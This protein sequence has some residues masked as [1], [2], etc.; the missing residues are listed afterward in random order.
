MSELVERESQLEALSARLQAAAAGAG[1]VALVCG[2]AGIGKTSLVRA[3]AGQ[4]RGVTLWWGACDALQTPHPLAPLHDI[5][6]TAD[7][8][9]R[10]LIDSD[11]SRSALFEAVL[12]ELRDRP[13]LVVIEDAHW[14]DGATLDLIKFIGRRIERLPALLVVTYRDDEVGAQ[15]PL[16]R[17]IG[18]IPAQA[19]ARIDLAGLS[20]GAVEALA[21]QALR[22]PEGVHAATH[23]NPFFVTELLRRGEQ[24]VPR[25]V[26]DLV[27]ARLNR[28]GPAARAIVQLAS[29]FPARVERAVVDALLTPALA[30]LEACLDSGLLQG[31]GKW[32]F[33]RHEL[34]RGAVEGSLAAPLAQHLHVRALTALRAQSGTAVARLVHHAI[35]A[36][37][38]AAILEV[39]PRAAREAQA[40]G[41]H[42]EAAAHYGAALDAGSPSDDTC[43][44]WLEEFASECTIVDRLDDAIAARRE[45]M[46]VHKRRSS[47][48]GQVCNLSQLAL[49]Y[50][51]ALR[52]A[53][54]DEASR[55][56][57]A[58]AETVAP[59]AELAS[60]YRVEAQLRMLN[61]DCHAAVEWAR[62][63]IELAERFDA[64]S[65]HAAGLGSLGSA[66]MFI[67]YEQAC[68]LLQRA[69]EMAIAH[70]WNYVAANNYI[71]LGSGSGE[72]FH[73]R[74][75]EGYLKQGIEFSAQHEIDFYRHYGT[76]WLALCELYLGKWEEAEVHAREAVA[77][78]RQESTSRIMAL[79]AL[80]RLRVRRGDPDA[81]EALDEALEL[82]LRTGTLQRVGPARAAAAE[83][84]MLSGDRQTAVAH[85]RA[86]LALAIAHEHPWF[87]GEF[88]LCLSCAGV[89]E[90]APAVCAE[91]YAHEIAGRWREAAAAWRALECPYE[92]ARSLALGDATAQAEALAIYDRL[93]ARPVADYLRRCMRA[94]GMRGV[95]RGARAATR[96]NP[97]GLTAREMEILA[98]LCEDLRNAEIAERLHR[99][100]RTVD[101]HVESI[102]AKLGVD[103]R[104]RAIETARQAGLA[105]KK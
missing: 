19:L 61:R 94:A 97:H 87:A 3:L 41:S 48:A 43:A 88:A 23:G 101:H 45:L 29:I 1:R 4:A 9:F 81:A 77:L 27:L 70:G 54:A 100:V 12:A 63:A 83:A 21:R 44:E 64:R 59:D 6:R 73:L 2:E 67:D 49:V 72:L 90:E 78:T 25:S 46:E 60:A 69:L 75:A 15:H 53:E 98:L 95:P 50:V 30:D 96:D 84:A 57:I 103:S 33:F 68:V 66:M 34:A 47:V 16:R 18:E 62:K 31:E 28:L 8:G 89:L 102:Y 51:L 35:R 26:Q 85:A 36:G 55:R 10:P 80:G 58:L 24:G 5:A 14:A 86:G 74:R 52:N 40:R 82:A 17:V 91:P 99:S 20:A 37:D 32:L 104:A 38:P 39:A 71:N 93:G 92:E 7:V 13:T 105:G 22:S 56:A 65:V 42:R 79:V 76:A 11:A